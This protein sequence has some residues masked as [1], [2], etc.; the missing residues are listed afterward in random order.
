MTDW[1]DELQRA[2]RMD[3]EA[4]AAAGRGYRKAKKVVKEQLGKQ[5]KASKK[6]TDKLKEDLDEYTSGWGS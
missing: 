1:E 4:A 2:K 5:K 3:S 6:A